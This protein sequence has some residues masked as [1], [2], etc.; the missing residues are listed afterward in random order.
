[1]IPREAG[2]GLAHASAVNLS[3]LI[4]GS[5][6]AWTRFPSGSAK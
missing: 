2:P 1:M 5:Y 3:L 6:R 4:A